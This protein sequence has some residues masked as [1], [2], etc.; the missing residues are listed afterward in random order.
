MVDGPTA[1]DWAAR[2]ADQNTPWD[3]GAPHPE[4]VERLRSGAWTPETL[5][6]VRA[7][8]P[9]C[10][11]GHDAI[12]LARAGW[13]VVAIDLVEAVASS[14][15]PALEN[16]G[17]RFLLGDALTHEEGQPFDLVFEHTFF[18]AI[19]RERRGDWGELVRRTLEVGG[20]V[21]VLLFPVDRPLDLG[22]PPHGVRLEDY[23]EALGEGFSCL[24][25]GPSPNPVTRR[26][27][28]EGVALFRRDS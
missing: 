17:S 16:L 22:G 9:G 5:G 20:H 27:W 10:G 13:D 18:C 14:L 23:A 15:E 21:A 8:V 24:E 12:A 26:N 25:G 11:R 4:L 7:L 3:L 2:Y 6:G 1:F 28:D 19:P